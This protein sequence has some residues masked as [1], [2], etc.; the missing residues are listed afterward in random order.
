MGLTHKFLRLLTSFCG[1]KP[2]KSIK[3]PYFWFSVLRDVRIEVSRS[4]KLSDGG[5]ETIKSRMTSLWILKCGVGCIWSSIRGFLV[6][7][8]EDV[9]RTRS[10]CP[11]QIMKNLEYF[12]LPLISLGI[13]RTSRDKIRLTHATGATP[14]ILT[15][16]KSSNCN[17]T[18]LCNLYL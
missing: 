12:I 13:Q 15:R 7:Y 14:Y 6:V 2:V 17:K 10:A 16:I 11:E 4:L 5:R 3:S 9:P 1:R 18:S 8:R